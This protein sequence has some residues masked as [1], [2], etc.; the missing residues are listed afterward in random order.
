MNYRKVTSPVKKSKWRSITVNR[1]A[2]SFT[3]QLNCKNEYDIAVTSVGEYWQSALNDSKIWNFKTGGGK[4]SLSK[5]QKKLSVHK[6]TRQSYN[7]N[8]TEMLIDSD[9]I[10]IKLTGH[11]KG[12]VC[13]ACRSYYTGVFFHLEGFSPSFRPS[14][15]KSGISVIIPY[16]M[17]I[18]IN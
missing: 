15:C 4:H 1:N 3:L 6:I 17:S 9:G 18:R 5:R 14:K 2:T 8:A 13:T 10:K 12:T 16:P 11:F 7:Y